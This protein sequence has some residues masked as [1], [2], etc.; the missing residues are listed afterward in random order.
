MPTRLTISFEG[1][2]AAMKLPGVRRAIADR[3]DA[4]ANRA[5]AINQAEDVA[6]RVTTESGTRGTGRPYSRVTSTA[7][8]AEFGTSRTARRRVLGRAAEQGRTSQ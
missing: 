6:A 8:D 5:R 7:A 2:G 3:A 4:L 1:V